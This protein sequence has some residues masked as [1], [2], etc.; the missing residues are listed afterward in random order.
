MILYLGLAAASFV[1]VF[2]KA[3]QQRNVAF[4]HY[5]AVI[6]ISLIMAAVEVFTVAKVAAEGWSLGVVVAIGVASG[7]GSIAAMFIHRHIFKKPPQE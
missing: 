1:F 6:P 2:L 7:S 4:D 5:A 3:F